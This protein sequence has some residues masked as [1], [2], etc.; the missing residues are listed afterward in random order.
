MDRWILS[1]AAALADDAGDR[2][3]DF[4]ALGATRR[5]SAFIDDL[6]TWYLRLS[7]KRF[8]RNDDPADRDAAFATLHETLVGL[9]RVLAPLIPFLA[10]SLY[11]N[12]VTTVD[13]AAPPSVHLTSWPA[14][15]LSDHRDPRLE[16]AMDTARKAV[17]LVRT[18][19]GTSGLKVRQ[20]LARLWLALPA[21]RLVDRDELLALIREEVNV[22]DVE[23]IADGSELIERRLK[24]LLPKVGKRLGSKVPAMMAAARDGRFELRPD[25]SAMIEGEVLAPDEIEVQASPRPGTA[26]ADHDG[27]VAVIDTELTPELVAEGD[28]RELQRAIQD[29]RKEAG[30]E[31]DERIELWVRGV[32]DRVRAHLDAVAAE[33]LADAIHTDGNAPA[34]DATAGSIALTDGVAELALRRH[35][36]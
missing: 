36:G 2:L 6:S 24:I 23:L 31:L 35:G 14:S 26:V 9:S 7:R 29:L 15:D 16:S 34:A 27:L 25:G 4:D 3:G 19:R 18:L 11:G 30:L 21:E 17:E 8:S 20:P 13:A 10:E 33:T 22:K 5:I 1:R 32:D 28:A 12:L